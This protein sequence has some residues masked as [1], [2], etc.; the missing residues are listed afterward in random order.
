MRVVSGGAQAGEE[1]HL[2]EI[3]RNI[4]ET[5][6][7]VHQG[8]FHGL[9]AGKPIGSHAPER[10]VAHRFRPG[11]LRGYCGHQGGGIRAP[12]GRGYP[13]VL[14]G[15][16]DEGIGE[17]SGIHH[18]AICVVDADAGRLTDGDLAAIGAVG[19]L[20]GLTG[21][22]DTAD[23]GSIHVDV[24][25]GAAERQ[26]GTLVLQAHIEGKGVAAGDERHLRGE[27]GDCTI[28]AG[29]GGEVGGAH[30]HALTRAVKIDG[31]KRVVHVIAGAGEGD[32]RAIGGNDGGVDFPA[33]D[34]LDCGGFGLIPNVEVTVGGD[35]GNMQRRKRRGGSNG[36][37][38]CGWEVVR[39][40]GAGKRLHGGSHVGGD[41]VDG[42]A[43]R[44]GNA[45]G[46]GGEGKD[47]ERNEDSVS[48]FH[49]DNSPC[50]IRTM[51]LLL[52]K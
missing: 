17:D 3:R 34:D 8:G 49:Q 6:R 39:Y 48:V 15:G 20:P 31:F 44:Q 16:V 43:S 2:G 28:R 47:D 42:A 27:G 11:I 46:D 30:Q 19:E 13:G 22:E 45:A 10:A 18:R 4:G 5:A 32:D 37:Q 26:P 23:R 33:V 25:E 14:G 9:L 51:S 24:V 40:G 35:K 52:Y 36:G 21:F 29:Q 12:D 7:E 41:G 1:D 50:V 38:L